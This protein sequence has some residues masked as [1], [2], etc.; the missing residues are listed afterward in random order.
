MKRRAEDEINTLQA[1]KDKHATSTYK[2]RTSCTM[3]PRRRRPPCR[4]PPQHTKRAAP[5][6]AQRRNAQINGEATRTDR[7]LR[8]NLKNEKK[9]GAIMKRRAEKETNTHKHRKTKTQPTL[10]SHALAARCNQD[11]DARRAAARRQTP[12]PPRHAAPNAAT[13]KATGS[14]GK[15]PKQIDA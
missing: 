3:Q 1:Q 7:K 13:N 11:Q 12:R 9:K 2:Q 4:R 10:I 14:P 15:Q 5:R 8:R 6:R